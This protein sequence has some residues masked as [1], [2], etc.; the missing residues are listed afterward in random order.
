MGRLFCWHARKERVFWRKLMTPDEASQNLAS[1][2]EVT[3][4]E[5]ARAKHFILGNGLGHTDTIAQGWVQT[6]V[7]NVPNEVTIDSATVSDALALLAQAYS[8]RLAF[9]QA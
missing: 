5:I 1:A 4:E 3:R 7:G 2:I 9:Y 8:L 6:Q